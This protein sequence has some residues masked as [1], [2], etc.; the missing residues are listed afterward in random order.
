MKDLILSVIGINHNTSSVEEREKFQLGRKELPIFLTYIFDCQG[1]E[2]C[3]V[4]ATCNRIEFYLVHSPGIM[5]YEIVSK[6]YESIKNIN[7]NNNKNL[8]YTKSGIEVT[9]HLFKVISGLDS[10]VLG[11]YQIQGQ[12]KEA[13]SVACEYKT[14]DKYLHKLLHAAFRVGKKIRTQTTIGEGKQIGRAHV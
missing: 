6:S 11:E 8:F 5:G 3:L 13:Y 2:G 7:F 10:L 12:V 14:V 9:E 4:L 1:I